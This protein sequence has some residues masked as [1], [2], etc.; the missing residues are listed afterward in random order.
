MKFLFFVA[1]TFSSFFECE[2]RQVYRY[3]CDM[4]T[5]TRTF[6]KILA[7]RK[8]KGYQNEFALLLR[9]ARQLE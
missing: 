2:A 6:D 1:S 3:T 5:D 7:E 8:L 4:N 9:H